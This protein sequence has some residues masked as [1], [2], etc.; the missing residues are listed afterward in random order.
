MIWE[1]SDP[2]LYMRVA[3]DGRVIC[4]GED[5]D[6]ADEEQRDALTALKTKRLE[7]KLNRIFPQL[8]TTAH[9]AWS[10]A[11]GAT[12]SGL[13]IIGSL[14]GHP[15]V[16]AVMGYGGN[17]ITFSQIASEIVSASIAGGKDA[18]A[19]LFDFKA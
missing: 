18:D 13:Q 15:P 7:E 11:F 14:P 19:T 8:D 9:F 1:A 3:W 16:H 6:F 10:G 4:G 2:Y 17:G 12:G 5:E